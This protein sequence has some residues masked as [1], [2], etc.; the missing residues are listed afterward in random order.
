MRMIDFE[1]PRITGSTTDSK[2]TK[3]SNVKRGMEFQIYFPYYFIKNI[4]GN[5]FTIN[6]FGC[7]ISNKLK[8][9]FLF[10]KNSFFFM[11]ENC[12]KII[13]RMLIYCYKKWGKWDN[14][15]QFYYT[16]YRIKMN[17]I[18]KADKIICPVF[19][20]PAA[21]AHEVAVA[22]R[23]SIFVQIFDFYKP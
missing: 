13:T 23:V 5:Y 2:P 10:W 1:R 4:I 6:S 9:L 22:D 17:N 7:I 21:H 12:S 3:T 11:T 18:L 19:P 20:R 14:F 16:F 15:W 8:N